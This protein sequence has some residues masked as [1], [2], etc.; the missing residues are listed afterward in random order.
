MKAPATIWALAL[1]FLIN[2]TLVSGRAFDSAPGFDVA[3]VK[4]GAIVVRGGSGSGKPSKGN[5]REREKQRQK[6]KEKAKKEKDKSK[7][8]KG[9]SKAEAD[10]ELNDKGLVEYEQSG[11]T[12]YG[13]PNVFDHITGGEQVPQDGWQGSVV[14]PDQAHLQEY[15]EGSAIGLTQ[16]IGAGVTSTQ[17]VDMDHPD[18]SSRG[19]PFSKRAIIVNRWVMRGG[20]MEQLRVLADEEISNEDAKKAIKNVFGMAKLTPKAGVELTI[21]AED[22]IWDT[23]RG[24]NAGGYDK[25]GRPMGNPFAI[26]Y[27]RMLAEYPEMHAVMSHVVIYKDE[28]D[29][30]HMVHYLKDAT[31]VQARQFRAEHFKRW[32]MTDPLLV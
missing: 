32:N 14:G 6:E 9:A 25:E 29:E 20:R 13:R 26:G 24:Y 8:K 28:E 7:L 17:H 18:G 3:I 1:T 30:W 15:G 16:N 31:E 21:Y 19:I 27:E 22:M 4:D 5:D 11:N 2:F 12:K 23:W 10:A